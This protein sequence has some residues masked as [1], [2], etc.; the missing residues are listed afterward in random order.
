MQLR[1]P[2]TCPEWNKGTDEDTTVLHW[3][4]KNAGVTSEWVTEVIEPFA[5]QRLENTI[6]GAMWNEAAKQVMWFPPRPPKAVEL[7]TALSN[8]EINQYTL[9]VRLSDAEAQSKPLDKC[10]GHQWA[11]KT[12]S[13]LKQAPRQHRCRRQWTNIL[14]HLPIVNHNRGVLLLVGEGVRYC[15]SYFKDIY[16]MHIYLCFRYYIY[17][18]I[19]FIKWMSLNMY[20]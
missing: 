16:A 14:V 17:V 20:K 9:L 10:Y 7:T 2:T 15:I 6:T 11:S 8:G 18:F 13:W 12:C 5:R 4:S 3:L 19:Y 1:A